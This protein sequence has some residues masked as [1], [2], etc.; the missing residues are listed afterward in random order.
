[1]RQLRREVEERAQLVGA[2][3]GES[4]SWVA[5]GTRPSRTERK[6]TGQK[7]AHYKSRAGL[8]SG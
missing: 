3:A 6:S 8:K 4:D 2:E 7:T 5:Q 1:M